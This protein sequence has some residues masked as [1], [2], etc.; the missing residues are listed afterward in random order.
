MTYL[1]FPWQWAVPCVVRQEC[2]LSSRRNTRKS[3]EGLL[4]NAAITRVPSTN[5]RTTATSQEAGSGHRHTLTLSH[6]QSIWINLV[7]LLEDLCH[8]MCPWFL[9]S[10]CVCT[11]LVEGTPPL[12]L[13]VGWLCSEEAVLNGPGATHRLTHEV[14]LREGGRLQSQKG[15]T[16]H[17]LPSVPGGR[18]RSGGKQWERL[19][20]VGKCYW[21]THA[22]TSCWSASCSSQPKY[23][24]VA[25]RQNF[26]NCVMG[27]VLI[28]QRI[29]SPI[30]C[31]KKNHGQMPQPI[32]KVHPVLP[33]AHQRPRQSSYYGTWL[34][35]TSIW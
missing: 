19:H 2:C 26:L 3:S 13:G 28:K 33:F 29:K 14:A 21:G 18:G 31:H 1:L 23:R 34:L 6:L 5:W 20:F 27:T 35:S 8:F 30:N 32:Y 25:R 16:E 22:K 9:C 12:V 24:E 15:P 11:F 7:G 4:S 10:L 17:P